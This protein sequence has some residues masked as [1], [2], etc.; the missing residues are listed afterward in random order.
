VIIRAGA[1]RPRAAKLAAR[2]GCG[3]SEKAVDQYR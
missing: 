3:W 2:G 1:K